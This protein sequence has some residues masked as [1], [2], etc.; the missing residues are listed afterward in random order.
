MSLAS[1]KLRLGAGG[2]SEREHAE[3]IGRKQSGGGVDG[4]ELGLQGSTRW[5]FYRKDAALSSVP[6]SYRDIRG[7]GGIAAVRLRKTT[8]SGRGGRWAK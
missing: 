4:V 3:Q 7:T 1:A 8:K 5:W 2:W 6:S